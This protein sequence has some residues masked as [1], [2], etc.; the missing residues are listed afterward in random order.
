MSGEWGPGHRV[1]AETEL[2]AH[3]GCARMSVNKALSALADAG[4]IERRRR[5]GSFVCRPRARSLV[6]DVPDLG[7]EIAARGQAYGFRLLDR[8]V[9]H[10]APPQAA[11][12]AAPVLRLEGLH[13]ADGHPLAH[14]E[15]W[16]SIAT[17]P[18][19]AAEDFTTSPPGSWLLHH[20]P[21]TEAE[22]RIG[23][24]GA[25]APVAAALAVA[26]GA[27]CLTV[28]RHTW[29]GTEGITRVCQ[30]FL[31][32]QYELVAR[33]SPRQPGSTRPGEPV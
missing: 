28:E 2:M 23:A 16:V 33:F 9:W 19:I 31:A 29:R 8:E 22:H 25:S 3:Y 24:A 27:P 14:E 6:L 18:A 11:G 15:R 21:W 1:P 17:V 4:L 26:E 30:H 5:A 7:A 20:T 13:C 12:L 10:R 32:G